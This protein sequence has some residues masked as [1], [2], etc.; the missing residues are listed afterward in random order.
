MCV[1]VGEGG[2]LG[3]PA[4]QRQAGPW[5]S[6]ASQPTLLAGFQVTGCHKKKKKKKSLGSSTW[7]CPLAY[8]VGLVEDII[9]K[10]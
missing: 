3:I 9:V 5:G 6:L 4:L 2:P 8:T 10:H 7:G 1:W